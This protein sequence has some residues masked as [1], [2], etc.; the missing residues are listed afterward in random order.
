MTNLKLKRWNCSAKE[1]L[2]LN[3]TSDFSAV[4]VHQKAAKQCVGKAGFVFQSYI[5]KLILTCLCP[6][7]QAMQSNSPVY[8]DRNSSFLHFQIHLIKENKQ[9]TIALL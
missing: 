3:M 2:S 4:W 9:M 8:W 1:V 6:W 5:C 7:K